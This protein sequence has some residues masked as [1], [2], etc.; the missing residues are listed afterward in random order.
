MEDDCIICKQPLG[1][2][3]VSTL[4]EEGSTCTTINQA[5][6]ARN[7]II[8]SPPGQQIHQECLRMY[9]KPDQIAKAAKQGHDTVVDTERH[10]HVLRSAEKLFN[11]NTDCFSC[12]KQQHLKKKR[13]SYDVFR[14][15]T[16]D[17]KDTILAVCHERGDTWADAVQ[18]RLLNVHDLH[19]AYAVYTECSINFRTKKQI[20]VVHDHETCTSKGVKLGSPRH[21]EGM[22]TSSFSKRMMMN[23]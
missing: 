10:V 17:M 14:V 12:G 6:K 13:K 19:V 7:D 5:S 8:H 16:V 15:Q 21:K 23:R 22:D 4:G 3:P 2:L 9:C 1:T 11:F 20:P 18:A